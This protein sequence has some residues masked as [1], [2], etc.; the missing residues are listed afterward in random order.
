VFI[1]SFINY[2]VFNESVVWVKKSKRALKINAND[3]KVINVF[4]CGS[5]GGRDWQIGS[6]FMCFCSY[7]NKQV[8]LTEIYEGA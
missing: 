4:L 7:C 8:T 5:C 3:N 1:K 2:G 6:N